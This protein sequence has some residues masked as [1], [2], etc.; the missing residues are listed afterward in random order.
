MAAALPAAPARWPCAGPASG[1]RPSCQVG[2]RLLVGWVERL[3]RLPDLV[4]PSVNRSP[5]SRSVTV[6]A[7]LG[8]VAHEVA[9]AEAVVVLADQPAHA[10]D[11]LVEA[12]RPTRRAARRWCR[13][14]QA[15]DDRVGRQLAGLQR[16]QHARRIQRIEEAERVADQHP[17]VAGDLRRAI[18]VVARRE[19][20][21]D[22]LRVL[23]AL[24]HRRACARLLPDRSARGCPCGP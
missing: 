17:A 3:H 7:Q 15:F 8:I 14:S 12:R 4:D 11:A 5:I 1:G 22:A 9:E 6:F 10:V 2:R 18:R 19:V 13:P 20:A 16:E 24:L 23:D 21:G